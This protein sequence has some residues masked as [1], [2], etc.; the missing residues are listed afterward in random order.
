[1]KNNKKLM[2]GILSVLL[3][4]LIIV[5]LINTY[6]GNAFIGS[7][8][9]AYQIEN[10]KVKITINIKKDYT[11][12]IETESKIKGSSTTT[13]EEGKWK[14]DNSK[15]VITSFAGDAADTDL[16]LKNE[17]VLCIATETCDDDS[18]FHRL[19]MFKKIEYRTLKTT[20]NIESSENEKVE[21]K[22]NENSQEDIGK[23]V[24]DD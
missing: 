22:V 17:N 6:T 19:K 13:I 9:N 23:I 24:N 4:T 2:I 11:L 16:F 7:W 10:T 12:T 14:I 21:E 8:Y 1:M 15:L 18:A 20:S 3:L 5:L